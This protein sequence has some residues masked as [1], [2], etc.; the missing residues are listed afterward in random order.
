MISNV[1]ADPETYTDVLNR[2]EAAGCKV[3]MKEEYKSLVKHGT[4]KSVPP[5]PIR[6]IVWRIWGFRTKYQGTENEKDCIKFKTRMVTK[7]FS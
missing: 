3:E 7:V 5:S 1:L 4:W 2:S 6:N